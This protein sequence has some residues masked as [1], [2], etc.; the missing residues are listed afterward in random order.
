MRVDGVRWLG[1]DGR[2]WL[3]ALLVGFGLRAGFAAIHPRFQGDTLIY[4]DLAH[5]VLAHGVY[6]LTE[7]G[8]VRATLIRLPGYPLFLALC[9]LLFGTG[10]YLGV[11]WVQVLIDLL[12]CWLLGRLAERLFG[13]RVGLACLSLA[14]LC[15]FTANYAAAA[16][17]ETLSIFC[18]VVAFWGLAGWRDA[19]RGGDR[20]L[21]WAGAIGAALSGAALL[22]PD[23]V[24]LSGAVVPVMGWVAWRQWL[25]R[26]E[27]QVPRSEVDKERR[28]TR[29]PFGNDNH[30]GHGESGLAGQ[31]SRA[32]V[33]VLLVAGL[34]VGCLGVWTARN[35]RVYHV[36][37]PLAPKYANDPG[38]SAP[39]GFARW[40]RTWGVGLGDTAR[41]YWEY[42]GSALSTADLPPWATDGA[43]QRTETE[44]I[45]AR[46]NEETSSTP[47][48]EAAFERLARERERAHPL[49]TFL[50][51]PLARLGDMWLRPRTELLPKMP[52]RWWSFSRRPRAASFALLYGLLNLAL[53]GLALRGLW[54]WRRAGWGGYGVMAAAMVGYVCLRSGLLLTIDNSEPRYVLEGY[55]VVLLLA[56]VAVSAGSGSGA[57]QSGSQKDLSTNRL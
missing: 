45:Y 15:P 20:G 14:T 34:V 47:A 31:G 35:W 28:Q 26:E 56:A 23:G 6:G 21:R 11:I 19:L 5:N 40:Y 22:R 1:R 3:A 54:V 27:K 42:D 17:T 30:G 37:Q 18:A 55:P 8:A 52:V 10:N 44:A 38:E 48:V 32:A 49:R 51:M 13:A 29:I 43:A 12:G 46:Y 57:C 25:G 33:G 9:F 39:T 41:V 7:N 36:V 53:L 50:V 16:L 24:L 2:G 4:G